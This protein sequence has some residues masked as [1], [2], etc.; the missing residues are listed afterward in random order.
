MVPSLV[1]RA[2][3]MK[4]AEMGRSVQRRTGGGG[5]SAR[6]LFAD[7]GSGIGRHRR[8]RRFT[9]MR[10]MPP[11]RLSSV[12]LIA[13]VVAGA[14]V[15]FWGLSFGLP[16]TLAQPDES[17]VARTAIDVARGIFNPGF[18]NYPSLFMYATGGAYAVYCDVRVLAG[19][20]PS[21]TAC[22]ATWPVRWEP[23]FLIARA[24]SAVSGTVTIWTVFR[25]GVR[26]FDRTTGMAGALFMA[27]AFLPVRDSHFGVTDTAMTAL[28]V[29]AVLALVC[30][31]DR[32][33]ARGFGVAGLLAGLAASTKYNGLLL[34]A[35]MTVSRVR[36]WIEAPR[37]AFDWRMPI[38]GAAMACAFVAGTPFSLIDRARFWHDAVGEMSHLAGGHGV[39]L[40]VGWRQHLFVTLRYGL[41]VP[42]L[43]AGLAGACWAA[44][45]LP[46]QTALV[47]A[48]PIVYYAVAG[49]GYTVFARYMLPVIPFLCLMAGFFV[50]R[51]AER[52]TRNRSPSIAEGCAAVIAVLLVLPSAAKT[53]E[54]DRL[55]SRIDSRVLAADWLDEHVADGASIF[56]SGSR[57]G[58]PDLTRHG[59]STR[60]AI[61]SFDESLGRFDTA[62]GPTNGWPQWIVVQES[63]LV[64]YS[65]VPAGVRS[66]LPTYHQRV[67]FRAVDTRAWHV[68]DQQDAFFLP[69]AGFGGI[70]RPGPNFYIYERWE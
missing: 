56:V 2:F 36:H 69:L 61:W 67:V 12:L 40:S 17:L 32:P 38:F 48:F 47:L 70:G 24:I 64:I 15:R 68:Y 52:L 63:P 14:C 28:T 33:S 58:T 27:F 25:L 6:K 26:A 34:L 3:A 65:E 39:L 41:T 18:F 10:G 43:L 23:F 29:A 59:A 35:P 7:Y 4:R 30:A 42:L 46:R 13:I 16:H 50:A 20:F 53:I 55:L 22:T 37:R 19:V 57:Y 49:R 62:T 9:T 45:R 1:A 60:Y 5:G 31:H 8:I 21:M 11:P 66:G 54:L 51:A 44:K